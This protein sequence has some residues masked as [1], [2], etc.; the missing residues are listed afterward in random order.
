[1]PLLTLTT[2]QSLSAAQKT[3]LPTALSTEVAR[4]LGKPESYVM[5]IVQ[6]EQI[7]VM[8]G[9][10]DTTAYLQLKSLGLP[11][12]D[13]E[14]LSA[15]LCDLVTETLEIPADRIYIEFFNPPR[16]LWGWNRSTFG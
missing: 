9:T 8:G 1:M 13:T 5:V 16:H 11:E 2:N 3:S 7:M 15:A 10:T 4:L 14:S 12:I 6:D